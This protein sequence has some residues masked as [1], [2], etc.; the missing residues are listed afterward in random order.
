M[1]L[2]ILRFNIMFGF[3]IPVAGWVL[4]FINRLLESIKRQ[5]FF[6][7]SHIFAITL[8]K[9]TS[10]KII[11]INLLLCAAFTSPGCCQPFKQVKIGRQVWMSENLNVD[12]FRN[13][14]PIPQS[15]TLEEWD[16]AREKKQPAWCYYDNEPANGE[17]YGKLYNWYAVNDERGL[18]PEGWHIPSDAEWTILTTFLGGEKV[19]GTKLKS[20]SGWQGY[21]DG[22]RKLGNGTNSSGFAALPGGHINYYQFNLVFK[23]E[24]GSWWSSTEHGESGGNFS[25]DIWGNEGNLF[26]TL[27]ELGN[28]VR[29]IRD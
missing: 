24:V 6:K 23:D 17:K 19:V 4:S 10:M 7:T 16:I 9:L 27:K 12:K 20:T 13:G 1:Q 22:N 21:T 28:S 25:I 18:A 3:I 2:K 15:K 29:C 5:I 14:D 26:E 8:L 11:L